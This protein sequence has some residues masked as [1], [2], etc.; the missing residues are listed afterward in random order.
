MITRR[1]ATRLDQDLRKQVKQLQPDLCSSVLLELA[2][3]DGVMACNMLRS[4]L[5]LN[6]SA[7][8][9]ILADWN[10]KTV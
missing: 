6:R 9:P 5:G 7:L 4:R 1:P 2:Y 3:Y 8:E 10:T